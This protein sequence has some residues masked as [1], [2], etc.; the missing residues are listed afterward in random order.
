MILVRTPLQLELTPTQE[1]MCLEIFFLLCAVH[2]LPGKYFL[3]IIR[4]TDICSVI[5]A[6]G[7]V[8]D[9][10]MLADYGTTTR[11]SVIMVM[12]FTTLSRITMVTDITIKQ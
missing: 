9:E 4:Y 11:V 10:E 8:Q 2:Y 6:R 5:N 1:E 7:Y 12:L 3:L